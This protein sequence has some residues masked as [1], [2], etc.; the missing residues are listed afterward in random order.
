MCSFSGR[1]ISGIP[2]VKGVCS[3][4]SY[5]QESVLDERLHSYW[6][7]HSQERKNYSWKT[8]GVARFPAVQGMCLGSFVRRPSMQI[9][10]W[11]GS[12]AQIFLIKFLR[13]FLLPNP[14]LSCTQAASNSVTQ[15]AGSSRLNRAAI[16][17]G[18]QILIHFCDPKGQSYVQCR[19]R[20]GR[21]IK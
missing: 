3:G 14:W 21:H 8:L 10:Q 16:G 13:S 4:S 19:L 17:L 2:Q 11:W 5:I 6:S 12:K 9:S 18:N 15:P 7:F 20:K 1:P